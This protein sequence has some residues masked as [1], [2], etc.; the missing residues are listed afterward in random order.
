MRGP[1]ALKSLT[2]S[3]KLIVCEGHLW[4]IIGWSAQGPRDGA[5]SVSGVP[6]LDPI[7]VNVMMLLTLIC[8]I[9]SKSH[10]RRK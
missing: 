6:P 9:P 3:M 1:V 4:R 7:L 5:G 10:K 2:L 8:P